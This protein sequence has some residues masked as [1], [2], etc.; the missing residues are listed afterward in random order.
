MLVPGDGA[1]RHSGREV[2]R[3]GAVERVIALTDCLHECFLTKAV[4]GGWMDR[5]DEHS[6]PA[7]DF[8]PAST[9]YHVLC[10]LDELDRFASG[11]PA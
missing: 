9:L 1:V 10:M 11:E 6:R 8:M 3:P 7:T 5:L 4:P 2:G